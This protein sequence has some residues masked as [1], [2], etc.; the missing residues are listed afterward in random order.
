MHWTV[1]PF[2]LERDKAPAVMT[3]FL[4]DHIKWVKVWLLDYGIFFGQLL[5]L[6][7]LSLFIP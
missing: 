5:S 1:S 2:R 7:G 3:I 4:S 6:Y